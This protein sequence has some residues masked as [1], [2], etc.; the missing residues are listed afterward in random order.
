MKK[1]FA[2]GLS[3][4]P[5]FAVTTVQAKPFQ[6]VEGVK[7]TSE[8]GKEIQ[9][10]R[11]VG[12][13]PATQGDW[14][15]MTALVTTNASLDTSL[16]V[17]G[18][19]F[20]T[21]FFSFGPEG[22]ATGEL[23]SCGL[24][25]EVCTDVE[26]K[27]CLIERGTFNFSVKA[28]NCEVG[29]GIAAIIYNNE[30]GNISNGTLGND[31][32]GSIPVVAISRQDGQTLLNQ[33][34]QSATVS[35]TLIPGQLQDSSCGATFLGD[36][37]VLTAAHC[38]DSPFSTSLQ[39]NVGEFDLSN[40]AQ[41]AISIENI[42]IHPQYDA[43]TID[44]DIAIIELKESLDAPTVALADANT[45]DQ[46]ASLNTPATVIGWGGR[47]GYAPD[48]G[49]TGDFPN[50]LHEVELQLLTNQQ[51]RE[52]FSASQGVPPSLTG[53][54]DVMICADFPG[55]GRSACQGDSGGPLLVNTNEGWQQLGI[56]SW[57]VGCAAEGYPGVYT[58]VASFRNWI[59]AVTEGV[60]MM[61]DTEIP[62]IPVNDSINFTVEV[63]NNAN[64]A[65]SLSFNAN[66]SDFTISE[67][68][69]Q[70]LAAE[71]S[72][73]L[74]VEFAPSNAGTK[75]VV[76]NVTAEDNA[77]ATE[78]ITLSATALN[79]RSSFSDILATDNGL[80]S[81]FTGGDTAWV[82]NPAGGVESGNTLDAQESILLAQIDGAGE[83]TFEWSVSSEENTEDP[84]D[85]YDALYLLVNGQQV[86]FISGDVAFI[87]NQIELADGTN[88]VEWVYNKDR[89]SSE[90]QDKG[91]VRNVVFTPSG[92]DNNQ[93]DTPT[94]APAPAPTPTPATPASPSNSG[95]SGG[96]LGWLACSMLLLVL[97]GRRKITM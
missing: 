60:T 16:N 21:D 88:R 22:N 29:G 40:G 30:A 79:Q 57:G 53:V 67:Q 55:G 76:I 63:I 42:Y 19:S 2:F 91:F 82:A 8:Q 37:W 39:L 69:C 26:N 74:N 93:D 66:N 7:L 34:G 25:G 85:P 36:K 11:I 61:S 44:F 15:W 5:L 59:N 65:Q 90:G 14:P 6:V 86:E 3:L 41:N 17:A 71:Q 47:L 95:S 51:C 31:F 97:M 78:S 70:E 83:L 92:T 58:R 62:S 52:T 28:N 12:G 80:I 20:S 77:I 96:S 94:P 81:W 49:P 32:V 72:C 38:V 50:L 45:T 87:A 43:P 13:Q 56:V 18:T 1:L 73:T 27:V 4:M 9:I 46:L 84:A 75:T 10:S 89:F 23:A 48:E 68:Q 54:T 64:T 35:A 24:A 33:L